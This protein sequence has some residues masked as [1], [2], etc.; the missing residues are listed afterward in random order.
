MTIE[1]KRNT[2]L[3]IC[4]ITAQFGR[5]PSNVELWLKSCKWNPQ[6]DFI[7][8]S[9]METENIPANVRW[10]KMNFKDFKSLAE[11]KLGMEVCLDTPYE[12]C[13]LKTVYGLIFADA[14]EDYDYW[15]YCDMDLVFGD[16]NWFFIKHELYKYDK[17]L[18][19]GHLSLMRNTPENNQRYKLPCNEGRGYLDAFTSSGSMHFDENE[20]NQIYKVYSFPFF[21]TRLAADISPVYRRMRL[22]GDGVNYK[23]QCFFWQNGKLW[24]AYLARTNTWKGVVLDEFAYIHFQKRKMAAP[25]FDVESTDRFYICSDCFIRKEKIGYPS[26]DDLNVVNPYPGRFVEFYELFRC[27]ISGIWNYKIKSKMTRHSNGVK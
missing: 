18:H 12:C 2:G 22:G 6:I 27:R 16:L 15:G 14:L 4:I 11:S 5:L 24:R 1:E 21:D 7:V 9:D 8:C 17:F 19:F 10:I 23:H 25:D 20:I 26:I 3:K 13:D